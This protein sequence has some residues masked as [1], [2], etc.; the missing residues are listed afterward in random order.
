M[1]GLVAAAL[2]GDAEVTLVERSCAALTVL[3]RQ[4]GDVRAALPGDDVG[5]FDTVALVLQGDRGNAFVDAM[6]AWATAC[7]S[8]GGVLYLAG[9]KQKGFE[10]YFKRVRDALGSGEVI[11]RDGGMRVARLEKRV[12]DGAA[13][14]SAQTLDVPES[15]SYRHEGVTVVGVPGVFSAGSLDRATSL[16]LPFVGDVHGKRVLDIGCGAGVIGATASRLGADVV[17]LDDDLGAV[18]S[19]R[20]TLAASELRGDVRHSD[21]ASELHVGERFDVVLSNPPFH[22]GKR[23]VLDVALEFVRAAA[24]R[25]VPGGSLRLVANDFLPYEDAMRHVGSV[26]ELVR[27]GGFKVLQATR[28]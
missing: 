22:V 15:G 19:S 4:F 25:L 2:E 13:D 26:Q 27:G 11:A 20:L 12:T 17:L 8:D 16:F 3:R 14:G 9:D 18:R 1:S 21:V 28:N 23:V 24:E 7:T 6:L 5:V 10:R